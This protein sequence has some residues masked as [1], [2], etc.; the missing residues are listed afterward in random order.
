M[1]DLGNFDVRPFV[2]LIYLFAECNRCRLA[3]IY[4]HHIGQIFRLRRIKPNV[5]KI[6]D[7]WP[8]VKTN[9]RQQISNFWFIFHTYFC[10]NVQSTVLALIECTDSYRRKV[11][12]FSQLLVL[13]FKM[14]RHDKFIGLV[15]IVPTLPIPGKTMQ[16]LI[17]LRYRFM[18]SASSF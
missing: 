5:I 11:W 14:A 9:K 18:A 2:H 12:S 7:V 16:I 8:I 13:F 4:T 6:V 10:I 17:L 1:G 3:H 15:Q